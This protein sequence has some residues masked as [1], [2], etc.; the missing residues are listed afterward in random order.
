M[1]KLIIASCISASLFIIA[2][3]FGF[4]SALALFL[5][6]GIIPGTN[7]ALSPNS[8]FAFVI[9]IGFAIVFRIIWTSRYKKSIVAR[10]AALRDTQKKRLPKRRFSE[11]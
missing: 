9:V 11:I 4:F 5:L 8:M 3:Q 6:A 2:L 7:Y 10:L 1:R